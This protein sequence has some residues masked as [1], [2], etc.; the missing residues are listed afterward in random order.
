MHIFQI[1]SA[2]CSCSVFTINI[3]NYTVSRNDIFTVMYFYDFRIRNQNTNSID[4][5]WFARPETGNQ[6][7]A[8]PYVFFD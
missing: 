6:Q 3:K 2:E 1:D 4:Y 5:L 8:K 7:R